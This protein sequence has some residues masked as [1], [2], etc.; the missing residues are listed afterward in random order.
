MSA[1]EK[2]FEYFA[3]VSKGKLADKEWFMTPAD[4]VRAITPYNYKQGADVGTKGSKFNENPKL[5]E[6]L[7]KILKS[8]DQD[9]DGLISFSEF[10]F[11]STLLSIPPKYFRVAFDLFDEDGN[12]SISA[13]EFIGVM[14]LLRQSNPLAKA[15]RSEYVK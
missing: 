9:D 3:S 11:F 2:I 7:L 13:P 15:Q 5:N 12:G 6:P 8:I 4:F 14:R 10:I 1:P